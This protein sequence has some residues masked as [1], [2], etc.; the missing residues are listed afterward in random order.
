[1][2]VLSSE[3]K[4]EDKNVRF[5]IP[6]N[7]GKCGESNSNGSVPTGI[8]NA[9]KISNSAGAGNRVE[10]ESGGNNTASTNGPNVYHAIKV[11]L[12]NSI[13]G[14]GGSNSSIVAR[15]RSS[16]TVPSFTK[17]SKSVRLPSKE[18]DPLILQNNSNSYDMSDESGIETQ[19]HNSTSTK[20]PETVHGSSSL[21]TSRRRAKSNFLDT[22]P[23]TA[24]PM[25]AAPTASL[26]RHS[27]SVSKLNQSNLMKHL[28]S[29]NT[30]TN[31]HYSTSERRNDSRQ[32]TIIPKPPTAPAPASSL[33]LSSQV[34]A[35]STP[36]AHPLSSPQD[37]F[38]AVPVPK[39]APALAQS[40][41]TPHSSLQQHSEK[42]RRNSWFVAPVA[43]LGNHTKDISSVAAS[44]PRRMSVADGGRLSHNST[45]PTS[46]A[47]AAVPARSTGNAFTTSLWPRLVTCLC[48][49]K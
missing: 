45:A 22:T 1:L 26:P 48:V 11:Q 30:N 12:W 19:L 35:A 40:T 21:G 37:P 15:T 7:E 28:E 32:S 25:L 27:T 43:M 29:T 4:V 33:F 49:L 24:A 23:P 3:R 17:Q 38:L 34:K 6:D 31:N 47:S 44:L 10:V 5:L 8:A 14:P 9:D 20:G 42:V 41:G 39:A 16:S 18:N 2:C 46:A 13:W 36:L